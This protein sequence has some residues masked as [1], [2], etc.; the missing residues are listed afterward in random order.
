MSLPSYQIF[1][2]VVKQNSFL[3]QFHYIDRIK[4]LRS[5]GLP[6]SEIEDILCDGNA[7]KML[8]CLEIQEKRITDELKKNAGN[9][10]W[11]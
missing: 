10:W 8:S 4:Y 2:T 11:Y 5:L 3:Q 1:K 6:L 9:L 7:D